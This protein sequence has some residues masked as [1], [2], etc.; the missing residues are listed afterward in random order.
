M[1]KH[2]ATNER[3]SR[4]QGTDQRDDA[5]S[6]KGASMVSTQLDF[7]PMPNWTLVNYRREFMCLI[8]AKRFK[9][10]AFDCKNLLVYDRSRFER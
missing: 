4:N 7:G 6:R 3:T 8:D 2:N 1:S 9:V 5:P 10:M